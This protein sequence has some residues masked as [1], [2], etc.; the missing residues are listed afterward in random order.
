MTILEERTLAVDD[1]VVAQTPI[2]LTVRPTLHPLPSA[3]QTKRTLSGFSRRDA[4]LIGGAFVSALSTTMLIFGRLTPL[5]GTFGFVAVA[6]VIF[7]VTYGALVALTDNRP[8]VVDK[9]MSVVMASAALL[10][11][12][13]LASVIG[14]VLYRGRKALFHANF[15]TDDLS[16]AGPLDPVTVGGIWHAVVGTLI[17]T[18][19]AL[20]LTVPLAVLCAV[21]LNESRSKTANLVR[22]VVTAMTALPS[23]VAGLFIFAVWILWLGNERSGRAASIA[24]SIM[25][26]PIIVRS[27]DV[28]L[29][30]V[31]G[32]LREASSALGA[33]QWRVVWHVVLP[34]ARP[35]LTTSVILGVARGIGETAPIL[36]TAGF[37]AS[38]NY[39]P[40]HGPMASL[41]LVAFNLVR[42]PQPSQIARGFATAAVLMILVLIL[43][44]AARVFGGK[45]PGQQSGRQ[46]RRSA[47]HSYDDM[48]RFESLRLA[49]SPPGVASAPYDYEQSDSTGEFR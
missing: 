10:A 16:L 7:M 39:N 32:S 31:P 3:P 26:L 23:I 40:E 5:D 43:F 18:S 15:Y 11:G 46:A 34:T 24:I 37:T 17:I 38:A 48:S 4:L 45:Q 8:A 21:F 44:S 28:V 22:T 20:V 35:G 41:P 47:R 12:G 6:W 30:L 1:L 9:L 33:P 27:A 19:I 36:L 14:F 49:P 13:A 42:S 2:V 25:M 29:R